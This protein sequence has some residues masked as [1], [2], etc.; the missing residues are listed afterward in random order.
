MFS[1]LKLI[2]LFDSADQARKNLLLINFNYADMSVTT[3]AEQP[4]WNT[5]SVLANIGG[6]FGLFI[7]ASLLSCFELVELLFNSAAM[8]IKF[9]KET[10]FERKC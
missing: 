5:F 8:I 6:N 1:S 9:Y 10:K 3:V 4:Y 7:G 2:S